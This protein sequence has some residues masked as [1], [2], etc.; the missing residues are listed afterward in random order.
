MLR[1]AVIDDERLSGFYLKKLLEKRKEIAFVTLF[2]KP[3]ELMEVLPSLSPDVVFIDVEM[4]GMTGLE[5]ASRIQEMYEEA[6]LIFTT[7]HAKYAIDAFRVHASGYLLKPVNERELDE[8]IERIVKR[9]K[10][11]R[12]PLIETKETKETAGE[13]NGRA[14]IKCFGTFEVF[15]AAGES[16][17]R[18]PT[19]K[20]E[21]L[22]AYLLLH[23]EGMLSAWSIC[24]ALWPEND[25]EKVIQNL[26]TT[27]FRMKKTLQSHGIRFEL[28]S[29]KGEYWFQI[30]ET[31]DCI[32]FLSIQKDRRRITPKLVQELEE[33]LSLYQGPIFGDK[34]Y[35]W[36][37]GERAQMASLYAEYLKKLSRWYMEQ[38]EDEKALSL[39]N[40]LVEQE[41]YDEEAHEWILRLY[42]KMGDKAAFF[43]HYHFLEEG[44]E[45][46][47]GADLSPKLRRLY[48]SIR[49][50]G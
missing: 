49:Q 27:V 19:A 44:M 22:F 29:K 35:P 36:C 16:P 4:P 5:I 50:N 13:E 47:L 30:F 45:R 40:Q 3:S 42:I 31:N 24:E 8:E 14:H 28:K 38:R 46:E 6:D 26:H 23:S 15:G 39:L 12:S 2:T 20:A 25:P 11:L 1:A 7:A 21:E 48:F 33:T 9:K 17:I 41:P 32:R 43:R 18:F 34:D 10:A 37:G